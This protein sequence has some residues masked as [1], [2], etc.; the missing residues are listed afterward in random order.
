MEVSFI[1]NGCLA[2][3]LWSCAKIIIVYGVLGS[4]ALNVILLSL[5]LIEYMKTGTSILWGFAEVENGLVIWNAII[6]GIFESVS[7]SDLLE[8]IFGDAGEVVALLVNFFPNL[9]KV[10]FPA[11][12]SEYLPSLLRDVA[13]FASAKLLFFLFASL[14]KMLAAY[15]GFAY[16][17]TLSVVSVLWLFASFTC[18]NCGIMFLERRVFASSVSLL[19]WII[20]IV[21][22]LIHVVLLAWAAKGRVII[23]LKVLSVDTI[24]SA[25]QNFS[26]WFLCGCVAGMLNVSTSFICFLCFMVGAALLATKNIFA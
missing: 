2:S 16:R 15:K 12:W 1:K 4:I 20:I 25:L 6:D 24:Y 5:G 23:A 7:F 18:A 3:I 19:Y 22:V 11:V 13:L 21:S 8:A 26:A 9:R 10:D 17:L 14:N